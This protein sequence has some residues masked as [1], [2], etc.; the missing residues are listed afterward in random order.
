MDY[1]FHVE[2]R[3]ILLITKQKPSMLNTNLNTKMLLDIH[4]MKGNAKVLPTK[5]SNPNLQRCSFNTLFELV[6]RKWS[7]FILSHLFLDGQ[8]TF[9]ELKR[10]LI[11]CE[12][13]TISNKMLADRLKELENGGLI[14]REVKDERPVRVY[15]TLTEQGVEFKD[16]I[17]VFNNWNLKWLHGNKFG[18]GKH[19]TECSFRRLLEQLENK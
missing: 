1:F 2:L 7:L 10:R 12:G 15:Y 14:K 9:S 18:T 17:L 11:G 4:K 13:E 6:S 19:C 5:S 3:T 16:V 8:M